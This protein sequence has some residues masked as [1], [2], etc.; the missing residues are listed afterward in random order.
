MCLLNAD[1][2][3][4]SDSGNNRILAVD[5]R[6]GRVEYTIGSGRCG[7]RDGSYDEAEFD[8]PQGLA[9]DPKTNTLYV[10][11]TFNDLIRSIDLNERKVKRIGGVPNKERRI[12]EYDYV[13][14][15]RAQEQA[16]SSPWDL[17][18]IERDSNKFLMIACAGTHQIWLETLSTTSAQPYLNWWKTTPKIEWNSLVCVAGNGK[19]RNKN[20]SYPMQASFAQPSGLC[21]S[22]SND[23]IYVADAESSTIRQVSLKDGNVK[24]LAGGDQMQPDN[25]FAYGDKD[26]IGLVLFYLLS[27]ICDILNLFGSDQQL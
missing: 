1:L 7:F 13:G 20:N 26:G 17:C 18:L 12:G 23:C 5:T 24:A 2:L 21:F 6:S 27:D 4:V 9:V 14:G 3:F 8:W 10:A 25:L 22:L 15:R 11:D 19:E 16:I